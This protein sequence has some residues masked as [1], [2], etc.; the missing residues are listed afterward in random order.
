MTLPGH[1]SVAQIQIAT[2]MGALG[3]LLALSSGVCAKDDPEPVPLVQS[4]LAKTEL[5]DLKTCI[6]QMGKLIDTQLTVQ[7]LTSQL[8][9]HCKELPTAPEIRECLRAVGEPKNE[10]SALAPSLRT[11]ELL[12]SQSRLDSSP[13][14]VLRV[15]SDDMVEEAGRPSRP[16]LLIQCREETTSLAIRGEWFLTGQLP[17]TWQI[18]QAK[19]VSQ[20]WQASDDNKAAV[21]WGGALAIPVIKAMLGK[22]L[23]VARV[24]PRTGGPKEM[25]FNIANLDS[26]IDPLRK[27]CKW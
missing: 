2:L 12:K 13:F 11:W 3:V 25:G 9:H 17:V 27:A 10:A 6:V 26:F 5:A 24:T 19:A 22:S 18:D 21:L 16:I 8:V 4:C 7:R 23:F 14:L 1:T 20:T 15:E